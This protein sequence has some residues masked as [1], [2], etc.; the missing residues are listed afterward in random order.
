MDDTMKQWNTTGNYS[1]AP[2]GFHCLA[3]I[4]D[5]ILYADIAGIVDGLE[6]SSGCS[7]N[8]RPG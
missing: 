1:L 8:D 3:R 5:L 4:D 6:P 2:V 7:E